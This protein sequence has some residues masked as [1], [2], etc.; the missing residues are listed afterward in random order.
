[1][2]TTREKLKSSEPD[3]EKTKK[4]SMKKYC[5]NMVRGTN[6]PT[7]IRTNKIRYFEL[8]KTSFSASLCNL[9]QL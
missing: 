9:S 4:G 5:K 7:K 6:I 1:M 8:E 3:T 2:I